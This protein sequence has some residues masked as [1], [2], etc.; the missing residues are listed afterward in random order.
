MAQRYEQL[1]KQY[2]QEVRRGAMLEYK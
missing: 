2:L 1:S